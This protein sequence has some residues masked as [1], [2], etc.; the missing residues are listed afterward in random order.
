LYTRNNKDVKSKG[1]T[2]N[3]IVAALLAC[4]LLLP[5]AVHAQQKPR[6][7]ADTELLACVATIS[8][9]YKDDGTS[10]IRVQFLGER[11]ALSFYPDYMAY[12]GTV[13]PLTPAQAQRWE[14]TLAL[15]RDA[16]RQRVKVALRVD[17]QS[18]KVESIEVRYHVPC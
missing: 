11:T 4:A 13:P 9:T 3:A 12:V 1:D 16:A 7:G 17:G 15:L 6:A 5:A 2:M 14:S 8:R 18:R 10:S